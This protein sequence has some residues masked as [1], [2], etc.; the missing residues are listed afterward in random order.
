[1]GAFFALS[2]VDKSGSATGSPLLLILPVF[3]D[4]PGASFAT[5]TISRPL[6][7]EFRP[8]LQD[9]RRVLGSREFVIALDEEPVL[10]LVARLAAH[11]HQM[12]AALELLAGELELEMALGEALVRIADRRPGSAVP[13]EDG[14]AAILALRNCPFEPAVFERMILDFDREPLLSGD[15]LGPRVTAQLFKTPS[16]SSRKS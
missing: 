11:P 4:Q 14:P 16:S 8:L 13:D 7:A 15:E 12:P 2:T 9:V 5:S 3:D 6:A 1:M 10:V